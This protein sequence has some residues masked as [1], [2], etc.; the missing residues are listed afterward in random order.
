MLWNTSLLD[1]FTIEATDGRIGSISDCLFDDTTM[2]VRWFVV[3]TGNFLPGRKVLLPP[4]ATTPDEDH[5]VLRVDMT[6]DEVRDSPELDADAPVSR[7]HEQTLHDHHGWEPYWVANPYAPGATGLAVPV[8]APPVPLDSP[9]DATDSDLARDHD[10]GDPHLRSANEVTGYYI[11]A[12]DGDIGHVEDLL[13]DPE[14]WELR[15]IE[16]D[17]KNWWPGKMVLVSPRAISGIHYADGTVS[18]DLTRDQIKGAP[19][20][21]PKQTI[22]RNYEEAYY[23]YYGYPA[24]WT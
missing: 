19:E 5:R 14:T 21:D 9:R 3:D 13:L 16:V 17:T 24:Y 7:Q 1:E 23:G 12:S 20:Y 22:D 18:L 11:K 4:T 10:R 8:M 6:M 2:T 15:Y